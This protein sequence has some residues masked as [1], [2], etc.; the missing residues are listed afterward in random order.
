M[1]I[2]SVELFWRHVGFARTDA[3]DMIIIII[4]HLW[5]TYGHLAPGR[6]K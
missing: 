5:P 3:E 4:I 1:S 2:K 6:V